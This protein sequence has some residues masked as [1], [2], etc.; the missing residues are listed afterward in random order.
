MK[1]A[2]RFLYGWL[3]GPNEWCLSRQPPDIPVLYQMFASMDEAEQAAKAARYD[4]VWSGDALVMWERVEA[5]RKREA[6]M[7][8]AG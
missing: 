5:E 1:R 7:R 6:A 3:R 4:V 2:K 8:D